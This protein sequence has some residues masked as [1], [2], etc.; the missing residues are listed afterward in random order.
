MAKLLLIGCGGGVGAILRYLVA[1]WGQALTSGSFPLGTLVVNVAGCL[2][3]G[4]LGTLLTGP[5]LVREEVRMAL[6]V[7]VL[8]GFTTFSTFGF[9][10]G[11]LLSDGEWAQALL[12]V[13]LS[14]GL[15]LAA[16]FLGFRLAR[17]THG[18]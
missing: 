13:A 16:L 15:G 6:L 3:I 11:S 8:G 18:G 5:V 2:V 17:L 10:T 9:E 1:G 7:G 14:N 12:N 4:W